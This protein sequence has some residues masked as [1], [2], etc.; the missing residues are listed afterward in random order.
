MRHVGEPIIHSV[1]LSHFVQSWRKIDEPTTWIMHMINPEHGI[2][3]SLAD[4]WAT[5]Y[6]QII[7][8]DIHTSNWL[9]LEMAR[10]KD[11]SVVSLSLVD[12]G[13]F[14]EF[15]TIEEFTST[16]Y[17][18]RHLHLHFSESRAASGE[19]S[20][21]QFTLERPPA[22]TLLPSP[23]E[24]I[25]ESQFPSSRHTRLTLLLS[26]ESPGDPPQAVVLSHGTSSSAVLSHI[27]SRSVR[28]IAMEYYS[29]TLILS[30]VLKDAS[31]GKSVEGSAEFVVEYYD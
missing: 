27:G 4:S 29:S 25:I 5:D 10:L 21:E 18:S 30:S 23:G 14:R 11:P 22:T 7:R 20:L 12:L 16:E 9:D 24:R 6:F 8:M 15:R 3:F 28:H 13:F 17:R 19:H 1:S 26:G 31:T 2:Q